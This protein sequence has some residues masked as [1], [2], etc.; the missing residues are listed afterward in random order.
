V[1]PKVTT[2]DDADTPVTAK[3][4]Y[5]Q[6][7]SP[8]T[9]GM[10]ND[11]AAFG[12]PAAAL[13]DVLA[14]QQYYR[15][16]PN[17]TPQ[18]V[19]Q[20]V[21]AA[22]QQANAY[23]N[24]DPLYAQIFGDLALA[25]S[26]ASLGFAGGAV[27]APAVAGAVG[28]G[29]TGSI[30]GGAATGAATGAVSSA[31]QGQSIGKGALVGGITGG[32]GAAAAPAV[33]ALSNATGLPTGASSALVKA[34]LGAAGAELKGGNVLAGAVAGGVSSAVGQGASSLGA[35]SGVSNFLGSQV[36]GYAASGVQGSPTSST[37][38]TTGS[39]VTNSSTASNSTTSGGVNGSGVAYTGGTNSGVSGSSGTNSGVQSSTKAQTSSQAGYTAPSLGNVGGS[40]ITGL[41]SSQSTAVGSS[42]NALGNVGGS[43]ITGLGNGQGNSLGNIGGT[44]GTNGSMATSTDSTLASTITGALPGIIQSGAG[45]YGSQNAAEA[46]VNAENNA[47]GT[48]QS[49]LGNINNIWGTQQ[50]LGQG[51]DTAL[52]SALG[53]NGQ[54][55]NYSTF[56]NQPGYQFATQQGTQAIQRQAASMGNA[57]TPNTA[58]AVGQYVTNAA[59]SNY[60]NYIS[61]LMGAAGLGTTA[62]QGLQTG[63][64][65]V[66]NNISQ[67]QQNIGQAQASGV[68]GASNAV[69]GLFGVNGAGTSLIGAAGNALGGTNNGTGT[70]ASGPGT[71]M[72]TSASVGGLGSGT[73]SDPYGANTNAGGTGMNLQQYANANT[74]TS[75]DI[76]NLTGANDPNSSVN[77]ISGSLVSNPTMPTMPTIDSGDL[78]DIGANY[79]SDYALKKD[80][81]PYS[82]NGAAGMPIHSFRYVDEA[83]D[84]PKRIGYIAQEVQ[85]KF[86][87][88]V[89]RGER[90]YLMVDY[91]KVPGWDELQRMAASQSIH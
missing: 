32:L 57:Y 31:L 54:P 23:Y 11:S 82:F 77:N 6:S 18:Q 47:I 36:G 51:A 44:Q 45:V 89:S 80:I 52:G 62:N 38:N 65:T 58:I 71:A 5:N 69:G 28:G 13:A 61:Q 73:G 43:A 53:T 76:S 81:A 75:G 22:D 16:N 41:G 83:D 25:G 64:Q 15:S 14:V 63:N 78:S 1:P 68:Q 21:N 19:T 84:A 7:H 59:N 66:G 24:A 27:I 42:I 87:G 46:Q 86:P 60:N 50:Q 9:A 26:V 30:A 8:Q 10:A 29:V 67:L 48:Q 17:I 39:G 35:S 85:E 79:Y 4:Q 88:A 40:A 49:T 34:G 12:G 37:G 33:G 70:G 3:S 20:L 55:A 91:S 2:G 90:G 56:E 74:P 72:G